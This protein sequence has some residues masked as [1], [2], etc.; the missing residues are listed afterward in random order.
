MVPSL[1]R[2]LGSGV[3]VGATVV[4][5]FTGHSRLDGRVEIVHRAYDK[6]TE[7][8]YSGP[9]VKLIYAICELRNDVQ[10]GSDLAVM[11]LGDVFAGMNG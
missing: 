10:K 1:E 9:I 8:N 7:R 3:G 2:E 11:P 4:W 6:A 5:I